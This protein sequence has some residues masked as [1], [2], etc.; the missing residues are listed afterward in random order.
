MFIKNIYA[1]LDNINFEG[2]IKHEVE[3]IKAV[4]NTDNFDAVVS[5]FCMQQFVFRIVQDFYEN[6]AME[7]QNETNR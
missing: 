7:K 2:R 5:S 3:L 4:R 1:V 6:L